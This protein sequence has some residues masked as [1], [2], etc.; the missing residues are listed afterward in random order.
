VV[1]QADSLSAERF[2]QVEA[3]YRQRLAD[4]EMTEPIPYRMQ[5][6]GDY[7]EQQQLLPDLVKD[8]SGFSIHLLTSSINDRTRV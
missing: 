4:L 6:A 3:D 8:K 5:N 2:E 7:D 1:Y